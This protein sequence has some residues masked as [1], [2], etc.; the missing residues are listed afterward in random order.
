MI[1]IYIADPQTRKQIREKARFVREY[2]HIN[3]QK[4]IEIV[5]VLEYLQDKEEML[6]MEIM[7]DSDFNKAAKRYYPNA[8]QEEIW[9]IP[10]FTDIEQDHIYIRENNYNKACMGDPIERMNLAHE[11]GHIIMH[12]TGVR[13]KPS[14]SLVRPK[15]YEDP[16]WQAKCFGGEFMMNKEVVENFNVETIMKE[17]GVGSQ[18]A[19][20]QKSKWIE[21]KNKTH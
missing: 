19:N 2:L 9:R 1:P 14:T 5:R 15:S 3:D 21:E 10:T 12:I 13:Y 8:T 4:Y 17:C 20:Y 11:L 7:T 18:S 16:E 6:S